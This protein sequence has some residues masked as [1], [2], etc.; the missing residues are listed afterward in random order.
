MSSRNVRLSPADRAAAPILA[1]ALD[2]AEALAPK[3][4][5]ASRLR[6]HV[7]ATLEAETRAHVQSVDIRDAHSLETI[8]GPLTRPAVILLAVKF[9]QVF[10]IDNRVV[11]PPQEEP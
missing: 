9:G 7:R 10:L 5:T 8:A 11:Q 3:G 1:R 4:I 6:S 2:E